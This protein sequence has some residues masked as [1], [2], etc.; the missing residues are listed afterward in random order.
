MNE[1]ILSQM[2]RQFQTKHNR[3]PDRILIDPLALV[4][5]AQRRSVAP[6]WNG[7]PVECR[8]VKPV[9]PKGQVNALGICL[10][11]DMLRSVDVVDN[12]N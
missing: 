7:I 6:A 9:P 3:P 10:W 12:A 5:L 1:K 2:V 8:E 11:K 4:V